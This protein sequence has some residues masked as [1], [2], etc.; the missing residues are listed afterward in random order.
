M[1]V[2]MRTQYASARG[3]VAPGG[4][5]DVPEEEGRALVD[6]RFAELVE[7]AIEPAA[8]VTADTPTETA[9]SG[10]AEQATGRPRGWRRGR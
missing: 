8:E 1:R 6:G 9:T 2:K 7:L 10:P 4:I 5:V 3:A